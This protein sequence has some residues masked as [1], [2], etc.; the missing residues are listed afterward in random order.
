MT[1][2]SLGKLNSAKDKTRTEQ[3]KTNQVESHGCSALCLPLIFWEANTQDPQDHRSS[4]W[5][6]KT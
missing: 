6:D 1:V 2:A 5:E 3:K 4:G